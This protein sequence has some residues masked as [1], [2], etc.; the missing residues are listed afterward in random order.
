MIFKNKKLLN[1]VILIIFFLGVYAFVFNKLQKIDWQVTIFSTFIF[2]LIFFVLNIIPKNHSI[3]IFKKIKLKSFLIID[4]LLSLFATILIF[5]LKSKVF[6]DDA[7]FILRYIDN[8]RDGYF[9]S[10][11]PQ[12]GVIYGSSCFTNTIVFGFLAFLKILSPD[13]LLLL[14]NFSGIFFTSFFILL[15]VKKL[16][17]KTELQYLI[18][19]GVIFGTK[20]FLNVATSGM[21]T[22]FH[23]AIVFLAITFFIYDK[24]KLMW[25][26]L[27]L[28]VISKLDAA[29]V[30]ATI[31]ILYFIIHFE[32]FKSFSLKKS[33]YSEILFYA[34]TPLALWIAFT[35]LFFEGPLPQ[36][37]YAKIHNYQSTENH[38]FPFFTKFINDS[39]LKPILI[40]N[41][42]FMLI[43]TIGLFIKKNIKTLYY[44]TPGLLFISSLILYYFYNPAEKMMWY[45]SM[46]GIFLIFQTLTALAY[47]IDNYFVKYK[48]TISILSFA[49]FFLFTFKDVKAAT[50]WLNKHLNEVEKERIAIGKYIG[51][52]SN[53][54]EVLLSGHG[55]TSRYFKGY[56]MDISGLNNKKA[57]DYKLNKDS[58]IEAFKPD[59]VINHA[60]Y[61]YLNFD[62]KFNYR[63]KHAFFDI[64]ENN[65]P[66]WVLFEKNKSD[67]LFD[68]VRINPDKISGT[69]EIKKIYLGFRAKGN[70]I[71]LNFTSDT[72]QTLNKVVFGV[73]R[74][75][76][77]FNLLIE[78][79]NKD[80][81]LS[82][83]KIKIE[84]KGSE[85]KISQFVKEVQFY[86]S[87]KKITKVRITSSEKAKTITVVNPMTEYIKQ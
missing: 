28:A 69:N 80:S 11:N 30:V 48:K 2:I 10:F 65:F 76:E 78:C 85:N 60:W 23:I 46:P 4:I 61:Y 26:S 16:F 74:K 13:T 41:F 15:I 77:N 54:N 37:A 7:G 9:Y 17:S 33:V 64:T 70:N 53:K 29:P 39:Y 34:I 75:T 1:L 68:L 82:S 21:E 8:F 6:F 20:M 25:L 81:L 87:D 12:D 71:E 47:I 62:T 22:P 19:A 3:T 57:T 51:N 5:K 36:S 24:P 84:K 50:S 73:K 66:T 14:S 56:V 40:L 18:W 32:R 43:I 79:F 38:W 83:Q 55:N 45:Y 31:S 86:I 59:Y 67:T 42:I 63:L 49:A 44:L 35:F 52:I 72:T 27:V 58:I